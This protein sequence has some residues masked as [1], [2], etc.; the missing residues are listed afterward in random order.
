[1]CHRQHLVRPFS[2]PCGPLASP[3]EQNPRQS[4]FESA[5]ARINEGMDQT[6]IKVPSVVPARP[7]AK[8]THFRDLPK[9]GWPVPGC[10]R[11]EE[12]KPQRGCTSGGGC[13]A[14]LWM[15][16]MRMTKRTHLGCPIRPRT[17]SFLRKQE[18]MVIEPAIEP[19]QRQPPDAPPQRG[20]T[21]GVGCPTRQHL[22]LRSGRV[23]QRA[24]GEPR[25]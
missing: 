6:R 20:C 19:A 16:G 22:V 25:I 11:L 24:I 18:T 14:R 3:P 9:P 4:A 7:L 1:M 15:T 23:R 21:S 2:P 8:R 13:P 10:A 5:I 17:P 12:A